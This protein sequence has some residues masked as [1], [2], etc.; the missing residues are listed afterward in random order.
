MTV[1][2]DDR[3]HFENEDWTVLDSGLEHRRTGYFIARDEIGNRRS[4][5]LWTWPLHMAEKS[6]CTMPAFVEAFTCAAAVFAVPA[7]ADLARSFQVARRDIAASPALARAKA[8]SRAAS[9]AARPDAASDG[10][11]VLQREGTI[12]ISWEPAGSTRPAASAGR[13]VPGFQDRLRH[14]AAGHPQ[15]A[16]ARSRLSR[17]R[18]W[19]APHWRATHR[20]RQAGTRIVR[21]LWAAWAVR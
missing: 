8:A 17:R 15:G 4:D 1:M 20:I 12:P 16:T 9:R 10:S 14:P 19:R 7:D 11:E 5:G 18:A 6:W 3:T 21:L 13:A 2:T